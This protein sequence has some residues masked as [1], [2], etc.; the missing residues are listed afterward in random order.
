MRKRFILLIDFSE[1]S[2]HLISYAAD[3]S[4]EC[5]AEMV[6]LHETAVAAPALADVETKQQI[7]EDHNDEALQK[8]K[9]LAQEHI[10]SPVRLSYVVSDVPLHFT[11]PKLLEEAYD[12]LVFVGIKGTGMLKK[13]FLGSVALEV[14]R[15]TNN[16][17]VAMPNTVDKFSHEKIF[18]AV[19]KRK[20][21]NLEQLNHFLQFIDPNNTHITFFYLA[22]PTEDTTTI[23]K[24]LNELSTNYAERFQTSHAIYEGQNRLEDIKKVINN[25]IDEILIVQ[26]GSYLLTD[27]LFRRF[28]INELVYEGQTP[29]VVLPS[30]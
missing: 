8:L 15:S 3:W 23:K 1:Y 7:V 24:Q 21:L 12:N 30:L 29:L 18:V 26:K 16:I 22:K 27:Q 13:L 17:V 20:P 10:N 28:L 4:K 19:N 14:I 11:L 6:L 25:Q 5:N 9:A 2:S